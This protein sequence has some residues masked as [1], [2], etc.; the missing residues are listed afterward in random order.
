MLTLSLQQHYFNAIKQGSK[1][2]EGRLNSS[3]FHDL[4]PGM[5]IQFKCGSTDQIIMCT[6]ASMHV[7]ADFKD[8]LLHEGLENM[9]PGVT[10]LEKGVNLYKSFPG[11]RDGVKKFGAL[12]IVI[13]KNL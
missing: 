6:V 7:Y 1:T 10:S 8:M 2:V 11:Y 13:Q 4:K 5:S 3:K 9:L 12:A